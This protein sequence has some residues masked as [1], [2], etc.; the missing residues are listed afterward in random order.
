MLDAMSVWRQITRGLRVLANRRS[1][2]QEIADEVNHYLEESTAMFA[3]GGL[4][5]EEA[6]R[7]ARMEMG[8]ETAAR[9]Q[10]RGYGWEN[11]FDT[12]FADLRYA[13]RRLRGK[14]GFT[15]VSVL[16]L[17][18]G[19]GATAA[20]FSVIDGVLIKALPYPHPERLVALWHT[21]PGIHIKDLNLA[22]SLYFTYSEENRVFQ[23][24]AMWQTGAWTVTGLGDPEEVPGLTVTHRFLDVLGVQPALGRP[25]LPSD[26]DPRGE[27]TVML[28]D[29]YWKSRFGGERSVLNRRI[30]LNGD[31]VSIIGV[32]PPSFQFLDR[33]VSLVLPIR[34]DRGTVRLISFC[35][36]GVARLKPGVTLAQ[37]NTD[38]AR[39]LL[40]APSKFSLNPG[41]PER[42]F[43]DILIAPDLRPLKNVLVGDIGNTLWVLMGAVGLVMA[44]ACANVA[45]LL[46]VRADGRR[47]ELAIRA[48]IGAGWGRLARELLLESSL[49]GVAGGVCGLALA[50]SAVRALVASDLAHLPRIRDIS[51]DP[52]VM[53][54]TLAV[55]L[56][57]GLV[58]GIIPVFKYARP[59]LSSTLGGGGRSASQSK[60]RNR[61][62]SVL[63]VVQV[64]LALVLLVGS[65][66]M[67]RT[68][69]ALRRVDPG[70][71]GAAEIEMMRIFIPATQVPD[72]ERTARMEEEIL[73]RIEG[74]GGVS[75]VALTNGTPLEMCCDNNPVHVEDHADREGATPPIRRF[76]YISPGY[77]STLGSRLIA[78]REPT[79]AELYSRAPVAMVSENMA[80]E[81]WRDPREA[82][83]KRIRSLSMSEW[84]EVIG[85]VGDLRDNGID[86]KA[87]TIIYLPLLQKNPG[88]VTRSVV[89][90][91]RTRRAGSIGL[92]QEIQQ[93]VTGVNPKL[94]VA[95]VKTL[96][97]V[98]E[99][100]LA[101]TSFTLVLLAIAGTMSLVLGVV[102]LY[103]VISYAVARRTREVGIRLALGSPS[104]SITRMFVRQGL[105]LSGVGAVCGLA[106][107]LA[108]TRL[109]KSLLF[110]VS[111]ADPL[112]YAGASMAL[113]VAAMIGSYVPARRAMRVDPVEAMRAE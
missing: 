28:S 14:P 65:G 23:D 77:V 92:R 58:F 4:T 61:A 64:A 26:N 38:V 62:R 109:M 55:S 84:R 7:A 42:S 56:A 40:L 5:P 9:E 73:H 107:A 18:L 68:F 63:V 101:R 93:A 24:I 94:A 104:Q 22:A 11:G 10:I 67:I 88:T 76:K 100:S 25:F 16:T 2:D 111:P 105:V 81:L 49:L 27:R 20:I 98:Y 44:I 96:E 6:R 13:A 75:A 46:L 53:A 70:F 12:W 90:I 97:A 71:A 30:M 54:F 112:T 99:R 8:N 103:G 83:G 43:T 72:L 48:A 69:Q 39:M 32:L 51:I 3:A 1:A 36:Q 15:T 19:I 89:Y 74:I 37:A 47:Q 59:H 50:Y 29:G 91:I 80:R 106:A 57:A 108:L 41:L 60:E 45:N 95:D 78:G 82:M 66:L 86:Q 113:V 87:P 33:K 17:A 79:W 34:Q 52:G 35:C 102:G 31:A 21:A 110:D 85:V